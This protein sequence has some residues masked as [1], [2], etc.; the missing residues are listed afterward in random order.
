MRQALG[1]GALGRPRGSGWRG[2]LEGGSGWGTRETHG[3]FISMYGKIHYKKKKK[4]RHR[5]G[6]KK[7]IDKQEE[8][9]SETKAISCP[10]DTD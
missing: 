9:D 5:K 8:R 1:P 4:E 7:S 10:K 3:C 2:R 6:K